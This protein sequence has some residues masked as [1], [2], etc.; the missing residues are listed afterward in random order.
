MIDSFAPVNPALVDAPLPA[1]VLTDGHP[2]Y[3]AQLAAG[4]TRDVLM[5]VCGS[6][7]REFPKA[8]WIE[9]SD[10]EDKARENDKNKTWPVNFC[11]RF[12]NQTPNHF[13]TCHSLGTNF[14]ICRNRQRG[15]IYPDGPKAGFRYEESAKYGSVWVSPMSV[16]AEANPGE[17]GGASIRHVMDICIRRGFLPDKLQPKDYGFKHT[18]AGTTGKGG[19]NQSS[20]PW[21]PVSRF[22]NGWQ[23]TAKSFRILEVIFPETIEQAMCLILHGYAVCVGRAGH[24]VPWALANVQ[25]KR[26]GYVDS[27]DVIRW[28]SWGTARGAVGGSYAIASVTAPDDWSEPAK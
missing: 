12:T 25:E 23:E 1:S 6:A 28:D 19:I 18:L 2:G 22:P 13:C 26:F 5:G 14:E 27:Y 16:Y 24:A 11:D 21:T 4:D 7:S 17:W 15:V 3:P 10:W 8:L 20:G 9:P